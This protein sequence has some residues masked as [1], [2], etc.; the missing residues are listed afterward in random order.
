VKVI[1]GKYLLWANQFDLWAPD[2]PESSAAKFHSLCFAFG[3][4]ENRCIVTKF[5]ADNPVSGAPEIFVDNPMCPTLQHSFWAT[6]LG[7]YITEHDIQLDIVDQITELCTYWNVNYCKGQVME[8]V[9][10]QNEAYFRYFSYPDFLTPY[11]GLIQIKKYAQIH[12]DGELLSRFNTI[13]SL[14]K[15][16]KD[17]IYR[18]L[19]ED[20][21]YFE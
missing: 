6:T 16:V 20:F 1:Q 21:K 15:G 9:G 12:G 13:S 18:M 19:V 8:F 10:L 14:T 3:L 11:S 7:P 17:E 4:A 5:E 2:I